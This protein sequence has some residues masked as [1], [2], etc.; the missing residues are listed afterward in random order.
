V[1]SWIS[2]TVGLFLDINIKSGLWGINI[3]NRKVTI[4]D[5]AVGKASASGLAYTGQAIAAVLTLPDEVLSQYKNKAVYAPAFH[6]TQ[7]E[8]F[9]AMQKVMGTTKKDWNVEYRNIS[10]ALED[11]NAKIQQQDANAP[12]VKFFLTH[13]QQDSGGDLRNKVNDDDL[14]RLHELG[15]QNQVLEDVIKASV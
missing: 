12:F 9:E 1:A 2:I 5:G 6:F 15:L 8:L 11:C 3:D 7:H 13:F 10:D 14:R 4:W